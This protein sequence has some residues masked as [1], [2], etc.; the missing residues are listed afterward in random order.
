MKE[1]DCPRPD[2]RSTSPVKGFLM[3][4]KVRPNSSGALVC[5]APK[6]TIELFKSFANAGK[7]KKWFSLP[8]AVA[9]VVSAESTVEYVTGQLNGE[10]FDEQHIDIEK[11]LAHF[12]DGNPIEMPSKGEGAG[13]V[14]SG[15]VIVSDAGGTVASP[16]LVTFVA[17]HGSLL[18]DWFDTRSD[19]MFAP[20]LLKALCSIR[21][22]D[23]GPYYVS[24]RG[25]IPKTSVAYR[26]QSHSSTNDLDCAGEGTEWDAAEG[27]LASSLDA[28]LRK[29]L[30]K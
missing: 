21:I 16:N 22:G 7:W 5:E 28:V 11:L 19:A 30:S 24:R 14:A 2:D 26:V 20:A 29:H 4:N 25:E 18:L 13:E 12:V 10:E 9:P 3:G 27:G 15:G 23:Y 8:S 1:T 17:C 6:D